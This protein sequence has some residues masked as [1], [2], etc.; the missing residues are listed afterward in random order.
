MTALRIIQ[1][2]GTA[3]FCDDV[4]T[5]SNGKLIYIGVYVGGMVVNPSFPAVLPTFAVVMN[6]RERADEER[7]PLKFLIYLPG[8]KEPSFQAEM[9]PEQIDGF[10]KVGMDISDDDGEG[11]GLLIEIA[12]VATYKNAVIQKPGRIKAR[13]LRGDDEV[14]RIGNLVVS[15]PPQT[16]EAAN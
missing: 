1:P 15:G 6:Y 10:Q 5:E 3:I 14:V 12:L 7:K 11:E 13:V 2:S 4:R 16:K 9:S 8:D